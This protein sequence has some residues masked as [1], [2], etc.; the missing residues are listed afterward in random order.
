MSSVATHIKKNSGKYIAVAAAGNLAYNISKSVYGRNMISNI[1]KQIVSYLP[2]SE[3][4]LGNVFNKRYIFEKEIGSGSYGRAAIYNNVKT[5]EKV[6]IKTIRVPKNDINMLI[7]I[8]SELKIYKYIKSV[9]CNN[10][11]TC[12]IEDAA[13]D[14]MLYIVFK[15]DANM[16]DLSKITPQ[17][18]DEIKDKI[19]IN[20]INGLAWL[21][22]HNIAHNDIKPENI[23]A[24][25]DT[26]DIKY[27]DFG[28]SCINSCTMASGGTAEYMSPQMVY[29]ITSGTTDLLPFK[30]ALGND[31]H[32]LGVTISKLYNSKVPEKYINI[33]NKMKKEY[34]RTT[35]KDIQKDLNIKIN[36][37]S[38]KSFWSWFGF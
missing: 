2:V 17:L 15:Y 21:H 1:K 37:T 28:I 34:N 12:Y 8:E 24:N 33:V 18:T 36:S 32:A 20:L 3:A 23:I 27:I 6:I 19:V 14:D 4:I 7:Y 35:I 11:I 10:Y 31:I 22:K 16:L 29:R 30:E 25:K 38:V 26:G 9:G 5:N 13:F